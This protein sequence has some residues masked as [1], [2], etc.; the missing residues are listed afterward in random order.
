MIQCSTLCTQR[1]VTKFPCFWCLVFGAQFQHFLEFFCPF[2]FAVQLALVSM[3]TVTLISSLSVF[4]LQRTRRFR[5][6][7]SS[8]FLLFT[9]L[10]ISFCFQCLCMCHL[11]AM[12]AAV[13]VVV[14]VVLVVVAF[15]FPFPLSFKCWALYYFVINFG[16]S[17]FLSDVSACLIRFVLY[18]ISLFFHVLLSRVM[19]HLLWCVSP[20]RFFS[21]LASPFCHCVVFF[22]HVFNK[23]A[24][25][26]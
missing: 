18:I 26:Q 5:T 17:F 3:I 21:F 8:S 10:C 7:S 11:C 23:I 24:C 1:K 20:S 6:G 15:S 13:V 2:F 16:R 22:I 9:S 19:F 14:V 4:S 25:F 12:A